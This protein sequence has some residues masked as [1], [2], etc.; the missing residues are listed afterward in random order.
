MATDNS[1]DFQGHSYPGPRGKTFIALIDVHLDQLQA[2]ASYRLRAGGQANFITTACNKIANKLRGKARRRLVLQPT[3][4]DQK[5]NWAKK[6][7]ANP[8]TIP[9][10]D[11]LPPWS[12]NP[13]A[14]YLEEAKVTATATRNAHFQSMK[15]HHMDL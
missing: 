12:E 1:R 8:R 7:L 9:F 10:P 4:G 5:H 6:L 3:P 14:A 13:V 11:P 15:V 2:K